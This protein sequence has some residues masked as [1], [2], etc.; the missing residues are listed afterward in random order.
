MADD[1]SSWHAGPDDSFHG[2]ITLNG[3]FAP[4][5]NRYHLYVGYFCPFA[6]RA[7]IV[8]KL[9]QLEKYAGIEMSIMRPYPK[10]DE[11]G[12]PGW[13]FN[14]K[15]EE[16]QYE[17]ATV[18]KLFGS[19]YLHEVYFKADKEY[20]GRYSVPVLWDKK[21][22]T[23]V[24]NESHELLRDLQTEFNPLLPR[25]LQD[26]T[27]YPEDLREEVDT[28][29]QQL[30][31]DLNTRVYKT[32][33]ATTQE[34]Y[35]ENLPIVFAMLNKLEKVAAKSGGPYILGK[36][37]TEVDVR[38]YASLIRFDTVYVQHFKCNLGMIRYS[39]PI[40]HNW[41]KSM[42]WNEHA[43]RSTTNFRH[44]KENYTKS[45]YHINPLAITPVGPW[46]DIESGVE[47][48]WSKLRVGGIDMPAVLEFERTQTDRE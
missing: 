9:K 12:W 10:G 36:H 24:N 2:K 22:S 48:D 21:L 30:Q 33:N 16:D 18:D 34:D 11:N 47:A 45:H 3:R 23:I 40:L 6:H 28:L 13:R 5:A 7:M 27:L 46:P 25:E 43:F 26:I 41:L 4:E 38:T 31:R 15:E 37:M 39:Y 14:V 17:G 32:G 29:G 44:I 42:Y 8:Y 1:T 20:K 19:K 35:E